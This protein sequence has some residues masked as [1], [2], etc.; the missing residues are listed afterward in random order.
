MKQKSVPEKGP[1]A[2]VVKDIRNA[3]AVAARASNAKYN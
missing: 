1:A 2:Q 3:A